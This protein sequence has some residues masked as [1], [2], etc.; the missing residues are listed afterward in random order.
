MEQP[1]SWPCRCLAVRP[2]CPYRLGFT[3]SMLVRSNLWYDGV[4][5]FRMFSN[6]PA[7]KI[8]FTPFRVTHIFQAFFIYEHSKTIWFMHGTKPNLY[9]TFAVLKRDLKHKVVQPK[10]NSSIGTVTLMYVGGYCIQIDFRSPQSNNQHLY[11]IHSI[12]SIGFKW[13]NLQCWTLLSSTF[14]YVP[15]R[16]H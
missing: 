13:K 6:L 4:F 14:D 8:L 2:T 5:N 16:G 1:H 15:G 7:G 9:S 10:C 3:F 11:D 12:V